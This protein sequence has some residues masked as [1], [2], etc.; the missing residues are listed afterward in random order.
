MKKTLI[1]LAAVAAA[2]ASFAQSSATV[3]GIADMYVGRALMTVNGVTTA[4]PA[5]ALLYPGVGIT[6]GGM[7]NSRLGF[8][9]VEDLGSGMSATVVYETAVSPDA[10]AASSIGGRVATLALAS[11]ANS[12]TLGNQ[13]TPALS[14]VTCNS[15]IGC[16]NQDVSTPNVTSRS[17]N[18]VSFGYNA[19]PF[20][21]QLMNGFKEDGT[22][23]TSNAGN[24]AAIGGTFT[25][26][27]LVVGAALEVSSTSTA[28]AT[29]SN[30]TGL[31]VTYDFGGFKLGGSTTSLRNAG[32]LDGSN[33]TGFG[34]QAAIPFNNGVNAVNFA[35]GTNAASG[36]AS[37]STT[38]AYSA[39]INHSLSKTTNVFAF[40]NQSHQDTNAALYTG[41][42]ANA[43]ITNIGFGAR[44]SF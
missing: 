9:A 33:R 38:S 34:V 18:A 43:T 41:G 26:G 39:L 5:A 13:Y 1:A 12:L 24:Y 37:S 30:L 6:N 21:I 22:G 11:G 3:Y 10:P 17:T 15:A 8:K 20:S 44:K 2:S 36:A 27:A 35:Y 29:A 7:S 31:S 14:Y 25:A 16:H 4:P 19:A 28:G 42:T 23:D 40:Y 32:N